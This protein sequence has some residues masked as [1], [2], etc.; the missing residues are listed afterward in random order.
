MAKTKTRKSRL[1][2]QE[3]ADSLLGR[4]ADDHHPVGAMLPSE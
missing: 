3:V 2:Y 4:I 1:R